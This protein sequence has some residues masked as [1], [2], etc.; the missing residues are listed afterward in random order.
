MAVQPLLIRLV[1]VRA[2]A[3][4]GIV[5]VGDAAFQ[6]RD[7]LTGAVAADAYHER[8]AT[9]R[10]LLYEF[11]YRP[12][13]V[14]GQRRRFGC[15]AES[16]YVIR[17]AGYYAFDNLRECREIDRFIFVERRYYRHSDARKIMSLHISVN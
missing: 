6:R 2:D 17:P 14:G 12:S 10:S 16:D 7:H 8:Y 3:Q 11:R 9:C 1:V 5:A 15:G 4:H 13:F